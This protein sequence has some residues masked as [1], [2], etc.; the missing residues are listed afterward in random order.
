MT[1]VIVRE[2]VLCVSL[3]LGVCMI[4][5]FGVNIW[6]RVQAGGWNWRFYTSDWN[7]A[8]IAL[9]T[10]KIGVVLR[11]GWVWVLLREFEAGSPPATIE[12][13][14]WVDVVGGLLTVVGGLCVIRE[15][16]PRGWVWPWRVSAVITMLWAILVH[17]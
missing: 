8:V 6:L 16:S 13:F 1:Q 4:A 17:L 12:S 3:A 5:V 15:F 14:W 2:W 9:I 10:F 11:I 7:R